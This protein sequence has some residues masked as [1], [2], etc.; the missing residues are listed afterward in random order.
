[1][2]EQKKHWWDGMKWEDMTP[3]EQVAR[4]YRSETPP[5]PITEEDR[6]RMRELLLAD[7]A[8]RERE[9]RGEK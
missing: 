4:Y 5:E 9:K 8:R 3:A 2:A 6:K 1:M 7:R